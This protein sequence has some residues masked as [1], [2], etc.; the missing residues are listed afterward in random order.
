MNHHHLYIPIMN[1]NCRAEDRPLYQSLLQEAGCDTVFL[2]L[3]QEPFFRKAL[4]KDSF[5][6]LQ[7]NVRFFS[8][9]GQ[10]DSDSVRRFRNLPMRRSGA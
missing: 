2:A 8:G 3:E 7:E 9:S 5:R 4:R 1:S 6:N 10:E